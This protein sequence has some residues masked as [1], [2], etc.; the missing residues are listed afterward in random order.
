M[1]YDL[2]ADTATDADAGDQQQDPYQDLA[3][4]S[5]RIN[6]VLQ[7]DRFSRTTFERDW[8]R[9]VLFDVGAQWLVYSQGRWRQKNLPNWFPKALT[10]K[11]GEKK[12][13]L[14]SQFVNGERIPISWVPATEDPK[15]EA[16]AEVGERVRDVMYAESEIE[17]KKAEL[18]TW[19]AT[20]GNMFGIVHY[21]MDEKHGKAFVQFQSCPACGDN[22]IGAEDL[23][24]SDGACPSCGNPPETLQPSTDPEGNELG[25]EMPIGALQMDVCSPFEIRGDY[26]ITN[27]SDWPRFVRQRR[28]DL[29]KAKELWGTD[30]TGK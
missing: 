10:N 12:K 23:A 1:E 30:A 5:K 22:Q 25:E 11:F 7:T 20:T 6:Q 24:E 9:N 16:T 4:I 18:A 26:R 29:D 28:Y 27:V 15:S 3:E 19:F 17:K 13:D 2:T 14:V 21:D 8:M